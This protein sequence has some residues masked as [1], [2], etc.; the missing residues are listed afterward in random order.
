MSDPSP[1]VLRA[2]LEDTATRPDFCGYQLAARRRQQNLSAEEQAES[3]GLGLERLAKL[4]LC[5]RP[6]NQAEMDLIAGY[7]G[8][9][10]E[11]LAEILGP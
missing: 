3:L 10:P 4:A 8:M 5:R 9:D 11:R 7:V 2:A 6:V 1:D